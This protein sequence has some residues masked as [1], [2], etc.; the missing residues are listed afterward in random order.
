MAHPL[1]AFP[2][3]SLP[4]ASGAV[5]NYFIGTVPAVA[6]K[7]DTLDVRGNF[8]TDVPT[9]SYSWCGGGANC[10]VSPAKCTNGIGSTQRPAADCAICGT[11][12]GV[13]PFCWGAEG[14]CSV[15][16]SARVTAGTVNAPAQPA[17]PMACVGSPVAALKESTGRQR[18]GGRGWGT[19]S[20]G[21]GSVVV[22]KA[23]LS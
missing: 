20:K 10:L 13:A 2:V 1:C 19:G 11:T 14:V 12:S 15:D 22:R 21:Q 4:I 6:S 9:G 5:Y 7:L 23:R 3:A 18:A 16:A 8:L 17:I